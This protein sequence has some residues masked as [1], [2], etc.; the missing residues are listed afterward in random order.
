MPYI[1][2]TLAGYYDVINNTQKNKATEVTDKQGP[3]KA[4]VLQPNST[5]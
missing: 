1:Y 5:Y 2:L 3:I 4:I